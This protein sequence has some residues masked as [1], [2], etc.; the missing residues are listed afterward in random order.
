MSYK[1]AVKKWSRAYGGH[2]ELNQA[3]TLPKIKEF[4][5]NIMKVGE[6]FFM[7][8]KECHVDD[9]LRIRERVRRCN[10]TK[11]AYFICEWINSRQTLEVARLA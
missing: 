2:F 7:H 11:A 1:Y 9:F 10:A 5:L 6:S 4:P 8:R 3:A